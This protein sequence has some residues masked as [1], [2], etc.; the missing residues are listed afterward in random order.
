VSWRWQNLGRA[1]GGEESLAHHRRRRDKNEFSCCPSNAA[2]AVLSTLMIAPRA[3]GA[4]V[5]LRCELQSARARVLVR[6]PGR[7]PRASFSAS[8][9]HRNDLDELEAASQKERKDRTVSSRPLGP[10]RKRRGKSV[11]QESVARLS[12]MKALGTDA[13]ILV[14]RDVNPPP[15]VEEPVQSP[16][17]APP[18]A[19]SADILASLDKEGGPVTQDEINK[20]LDSLRPKSNS[21]DDEPEYITVAEYRKLTKTLTEGFN[22]RQLSKYFAHAKGVGAAKVKK[23]VLND[24]KAAKL[25]SKRPVGRTRWYPSITSLTERLPRPADVH[26]TGGKTSLSKKLLVDQ[27]VRNAWGTVLLEEVESPGEIELTL[28]PWQIDLLHAGGSFLRSKCRDA[29]QVGLC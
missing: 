15:E 23:E 28:K 27:I 1:E 4:F 22:V 3:T 8:A 11:L 14:L 6:L 16:K 21:A 12:G 13:E 29:V 18:E 17:Q 10:K 5:C 7:L 9:L 2:A 25:P 26:K 20:Q 19:L 24:L